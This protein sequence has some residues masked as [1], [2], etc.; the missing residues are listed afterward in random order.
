M[1]KDEYLDAICNKA[2]LPE[3]TW[4]SRQLNMKLF[5]ATI[6]SEEEMREKNERN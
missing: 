3:N 4:K 1:N 2:G 6:F 5:T